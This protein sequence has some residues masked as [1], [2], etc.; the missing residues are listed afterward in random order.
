MSQHVLK[1]YDEYKLSDS[2]L[3]ERSHLIQVRDDE[4]QQVCSDIHE[5]NDIMQQLSIY[6]TDQDPMIE[7]ITSNLETTQKNTEEG[8]KELEKANKHHKKTR[9]KLAYLA[10]TSISVLV[11]IVVSI[12][13]L[14]RR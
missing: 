12:F 8:V 2:D 10:A 7:T 14:P 11:T 6:V 3:T 1:R 9:N 5:I 13:A 4:I